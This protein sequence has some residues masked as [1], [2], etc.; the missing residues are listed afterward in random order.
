MT[1]PPLLR[2]V[3][4]PGLSRLWRDPHTLQIGLEPSRAVLVDLPDRR[5]ARLLDLLDGTRPE[6]LV[7]SHGTRLGLRPEQTRQL[8]DDLHA[9][10]LVVG[11]PALLPGH[12]PDAARRRLSGEATALALHPGGRTGTPAQLLRRRAS[13]RVVLTGRGRLAAP[14]A[15]ALAHSGIG[16][17]SAELSGEVTAVETCGGPLTPADL[18]RPRAAAVAEAVTRAVPGTR[19]GPVRRGHAT[20]VV[21]LSPDRPAALLATAYAQRRQAHLVLTV[22]DGVAVVG[23]LVTST[24]SP[25]LNCLDRHRRDRDPAWPTLAAQLAPDAGERTEACA[26]PTLLAAAAHAA[27]EVLAYIDGGPAQTVGAALEISGPGQ[28]RR[29]TWPPHPDCGC[30]RRRKNGSSYINP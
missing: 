28:L 4:L 15:V 12:L 18:R 14:V 2:P 22:R 9:A 26:A 29:R 16:H 10:G 1:R 27:A 30:G 20:I 7:V 13:A 23:P 21:L 3:L 6:R 25:C 24:G 8:L 11:G 17:L 5:A 19:T